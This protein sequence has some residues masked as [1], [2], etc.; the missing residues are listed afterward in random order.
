VLVVDDEE[1]ICQLARMTLEAAGFFVL[2]AGNGEQALML[3]RRF[4]GTIH[5]L[6]SD[7]VM[8]R[9]SGL[10]LRQQILRERPAI[11][12]LLM[13]GQMDHPL[14]GAAFLPKPFRVEDLIERVRQLLRPPPTPGPRGDAARLRRDRIERRLADDLNEAISQYRHVQSLELEIIHEVPSGLPSPDGVM[15]IM[16]AG[17]ATR[18]AFDQY[19]QALARYRDFMDQ[20]VIPEDIAG[21]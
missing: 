12:V 3:S 21:E 4:P 19:R 20:G 14:E 8:P 15:R 16:R 9:M 11:Q 13:S 1:M 5:V 18:A 10:A 7:I 6:V 2:A 17:Q